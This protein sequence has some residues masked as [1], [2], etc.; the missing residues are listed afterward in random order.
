[1]TFCP[2]GPIIGSSRPKYMYEDNCYHSFL[3][4]FFIEKTAHLMG[5]KVVVKQGKLSKYAIVIRN[6]A[7]EQTIL[8]QYITLLH[9]Y[10]APKP[11]PQSC[12]EANLVQNAC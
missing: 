2:F 10:I 3:S 9:N 8:E 11:D 12:L 4:C 5:S 1:M 7:S 6:E